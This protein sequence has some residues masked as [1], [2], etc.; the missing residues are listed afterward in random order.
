MKSCRM[1]QFFHTLSR[2]ILGFKQCL[3]TRVLPYRLLFLLEHLSYCST[4]KLGLSAKLIYEACRVNHV[5]CRG[6]ILQLHGEELLRD[7]LESCEELRLQPFLTWGTLLGHVR[8]G[9]FIPHDYDIDL[10]LLRKDFHKK[11]DLI[12]VMQNKGYTIGR[13]DEFTVAFHRVGLEKLHI[14]IDCY[15]EENAQ[16]GYSILW[17][18]QHFHYVFPLEIF[19]QFRHVTFLNTCEVRIPHMPEKFLDHAYGNWHTPQETW[20]CLRAPSNLASIEKC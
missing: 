12:R 14:D 18:G 4:D 20:D 13:C 10:G 9:G 16:M 7:T 19:S 6:L 2:I 1:T 5:Q 8:N 17:K 15:Y 11:N 3:S